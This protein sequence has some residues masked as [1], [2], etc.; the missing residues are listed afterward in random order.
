MKSLNERVCERTITWVTQDRMPYM[1][2]TRADE[3]C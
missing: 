3:T 1:T 2:Y